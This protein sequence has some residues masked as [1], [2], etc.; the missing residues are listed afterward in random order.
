MEMGR[1]VNFMITIKEFIIGWA[2]YLII[3]ISIGLYFANKSWEDIDKIFKKLGI[4]K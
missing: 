3:R 2:I 1:I 4:I